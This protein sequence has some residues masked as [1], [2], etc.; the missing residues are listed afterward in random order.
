MNY[1]Q[2]RGQGLLANLPQV[3]RIVLIIN[4]LVF[5]GEFLIETATRVPY[6]NYLALWPYHS[7]NFRPYQL[8]T[9][10]FMHGGFF[11]IL[12]NMY[13]LY[14]FGRYL[15][16]TMGSKKYFILYFVSGLGAAG[17]QF[18]VNFLTGSTV[19]MVG[20]SGAVMGIVAAFGVYYPNV[21]LM[22]LFPPIPIRAKYMAVAF[23][24]ISMLFDAG[25]GTMRVAHMAHIGGAVIG[26]ILTRFWT[27]NQFRE[28]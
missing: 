7:G 4:V 13:G 11:H 5:A 17:L 23:I 2:D 12:F 25:G 10:M 24:G 6:G 1:Y 27:K 9:Y 3:T 14:I 19:P 28:Y 16:T 20:A 15:E 22:L 18:L 8:V 21:Q 26:F